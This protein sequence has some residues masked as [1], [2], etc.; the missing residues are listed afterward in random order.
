MKA[1][2]P[3]SYETGQKC[4]ANYSSHKDV[5]RMWPAQG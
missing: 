2:E 3:L 5:L 1:K 4:P